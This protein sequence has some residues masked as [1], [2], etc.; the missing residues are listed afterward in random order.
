VNALFFGGGGTIDEPLDRPTRP[1]IHSPIHSPTNLAIH[2]PTDSLIH[3][4]TPPTPRAP[5]KPRPPHTHRADA[6]AGLAF[7][8]H[9]DA[10]RVAKVHSHG[11]RQ[12]CNQGQFVH[13]H[14]AA[15]RQL[16]RMIPGQRQAPTTHNAPCQGYLLPQSPRRA[17]VHCY[18]II[19]Q[20]A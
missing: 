6:G 16:C 15:V 12:V 1:P 3:S 9:K 13:V 11:R 20:P 17:H 4:P 5:T 8:E 2:S 10:V 19:F 18:S 14:L 7:G